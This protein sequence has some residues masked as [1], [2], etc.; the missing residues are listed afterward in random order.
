MNLAELT[1][2]TR[3]YQ[4]RSLG[5]CPRLG[6]SSRSPRSAGRRTILVAASYAPLSGVPLRARS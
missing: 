1:W 3:Q 2:G 6:H 5:C 4:L